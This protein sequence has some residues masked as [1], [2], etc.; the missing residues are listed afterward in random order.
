MP[1]HKSVLRDV[2]DLSTDERFVNVWRHFEQTADAMEREILDP[3]TD[4][5]TREFLVRMLDVFRR[6]VVLLPQQA[7]K[8]IE[9]L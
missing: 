4:A 5:V 7:A 2:L 6:D 8:Q 9:K 3:A 1:P